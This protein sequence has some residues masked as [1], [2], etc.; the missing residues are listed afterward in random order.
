MR[1]NR[2]GAA[3]NIYTTYACALSPDYFKSVHA[4]ILK[5]VPVVELHGSVTTMVVHCF[6]T[7]SILGRCLH[8][9]ILVSLVG[10][11]CDIFTGKP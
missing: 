11:Q 4:H 8:A 6:A 2:P 7:S 10:A 9:I 3:S 5:S 1:E